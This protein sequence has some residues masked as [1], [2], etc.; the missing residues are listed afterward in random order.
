MIK[1]E[2]KVAKKQYY[3]GSVHSY[4]EELDRERKEKNIALYQLGKHRKERMWEYSKEVGENHK[5]KV[6]EDKRKELLRAL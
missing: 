1:K 6:D 4:V 2:I 3:R 5:P